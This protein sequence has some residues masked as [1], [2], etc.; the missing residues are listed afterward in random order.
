MAIEPIKPFDND[1]VK[2]RKTV[3][4]L[5][6]LDLLP[7]RS[8]LHPNF[9]LNERHNIQLINSA[10][11]GSI[12]PFQGKRVFAAALNSR[13]DLASQGQG[14]GGGDELSP[15]EGFAFVVDDSGNYFVT[16]DTGDYIITE[17]A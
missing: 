1:R 4:N 17:I 15:P 10:L 14:G 5:R 6:E 2:T 9:L 3:D 11:G 13:F 7:E 16:D 8:D 12:K